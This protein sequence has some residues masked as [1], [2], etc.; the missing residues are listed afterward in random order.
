MP[1]LFPLSSTVHWM[2]VAQGGSIALNEAAR[3]TKGN[4]PKGTRLNALII[5][6]VQC[7][8]RSPNPQNTSEKKKGF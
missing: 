4:V 7:K 8:R 3:F 6:T 5:V 1:G 2:E